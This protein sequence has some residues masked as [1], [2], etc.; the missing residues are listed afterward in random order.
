M[1]KKQPCWCA[2]SNQAPLVVEVGAVILG[3]QS[4]RAAGLALRIG[5]RPPRL[6][7]KS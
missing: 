5:M 4:R 1:I 2:K 3:K 6:R 7:A